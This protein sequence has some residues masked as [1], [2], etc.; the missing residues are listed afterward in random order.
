MRE[1]RAWHVFA[2]LLR[3]RAVLVSFPGSRGFPRYPDD[4][5]CHGIASWCSRAAMILIVRRLACAG[6]P[7][8]CCY[9]QF[10]FTSF[11]FL[12]DSAL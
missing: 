2:F 11:L 5:L 7:R 12:W 9:F 1:G 4:S 6:F 3:S 10:L 8:A